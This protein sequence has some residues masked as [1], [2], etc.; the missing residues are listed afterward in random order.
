MGGLV[1]RLSN[2]ENGQQGSAG[3]PSTG[4]QTTADG[5]RTEFD[6]LFADMEFRCKRSAMMNYHEAERYDFWSQVLQTTSTG[7]GALGVSGIAASVAKTNRVAASSAGLAGVLALPLCGVL[8]FLSNGSSSLAPTVAEKAKLHVQAG[9]GWQRIGRLS[10]AY[11]LQLRH[12]EPGAVDVAL[13]STWYRELAEEF[14]R[15]QWRRKPSL[16]VQAGAGWQENRAS[17]LAP[18]DYSC[19]ISNPFEEPDSVVH[20]LSKREHMLQRYLEQEAVSKLPSDK[21]DCKDR[22]PEVN[23]FLK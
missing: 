1:P 6:K 9:A 3:Q 16:H 4:R 15:P 10:H 11:R 19:V 2:T 23:G 22:L 20:R 8:Q 14:W 18:T 12:I 21:T 13:L 17:V 5:A 7:V